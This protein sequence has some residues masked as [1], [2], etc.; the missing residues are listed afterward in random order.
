MS[1]YAVWYVTNPDHRNYNKIGGFISDGEDE[2]DEIPLYA[3]T[4]EELKDKLKGQL[5]YEAGL[6][7]I[8]EI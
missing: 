2:Y 1:F 3:E 8:I 7:E 5:L 4:E 6:V